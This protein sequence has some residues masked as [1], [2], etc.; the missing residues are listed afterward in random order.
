MKKT[1]FV[2]FA[3][4]MAG[5][6]GHLNTP[7]GTP[8]VTVHA[9]KSKAEKESMHWLR[10]H[11]NEVEP[12]AWISFDFSSPDSTTTTIYAKKVMKG[13]FPGDTPHTCTS[14]SDYEELQHDLGE[15]AERFK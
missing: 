10:T 11:G 3:V 15:I 12:H 4:F 6:A 9:S 2:L 1:T 5:C 13:P 8:E 14:Q 7:S